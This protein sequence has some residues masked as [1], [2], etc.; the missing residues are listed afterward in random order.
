M[1]RT[2]IP[3]VALY[4]CKVWFLA[5]TEEHGLMVSENSVLRRISEPKCK[6][7]RRIAQ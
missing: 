6:K 5:L 1:F 3:P 7:V 4:V 2:T